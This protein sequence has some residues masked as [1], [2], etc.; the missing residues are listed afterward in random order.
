M[1]GPDF[2][3]TALIL[4]APIRPDGTPSAAMARRARHA[5]ALYRDGV[6]K[7]LIASGG[8]TRT[9]GHTTRTEAEVMAQICHAEGVPRAHI[10]LDETANS[11][12]ENIAHALPLMRDH[13]LRLD[14]LVTDRF[15]APRAKLVAR[16]YGLCPHTSCPAPHGSGPRALI[17]GYLREAV[18]LPIY[19]LRYR[20]GRL[21]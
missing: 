12:A 21:P 8:A 19:A 10:F 4:G 11:T 3:S 6:V 14:V 18:A 9:E 13:G 5:A 7:R 1:A 16:A 20:R 15:H 17:R 2:L